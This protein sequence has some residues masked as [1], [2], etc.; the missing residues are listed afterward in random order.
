MVLKVVGADV[1]LS[2][3]GVSAWKA[4]EAWDGIDGSETVVPSNGWPK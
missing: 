3:V 1:I 2:V 4:W